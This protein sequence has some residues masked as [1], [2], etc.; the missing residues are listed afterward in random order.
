MG[1]GC[2]ASERDFIYTHP[3]SGLKGQAAMEH[4]EKILREV[5]PKSCIYV[6]KER[7]LKSTISKVEPKPE[8]RRQKGEKR[9]HQNDRRK[10]EEERRKKEKEERKKKESERRRE[11]VTKSNGRKRPSSTST[12]PSSSATPISSPLPYGED[13]EIEID[14]GPIFTPPIK[15]SKSDPQYIDSLTDLSEKLT[16]KIPEIETLQST[17]TLQNILDIMTKCHTPFVSEISRL[18]E[19]EEKEKQR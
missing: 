12:Q 2:R 8:A 14:K 5:I 16:S 17:D 13:P 6:P 3:E 1:H 7:S 18:V 4:L 9:D 19:E 15:L 10:T 11:E